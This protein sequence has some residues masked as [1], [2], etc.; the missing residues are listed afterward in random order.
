[1][2]RLRGTGGRFLNTKKPDGKENSDSGEQSKS[3]ET[4]S[5]HLSINSN[6]VSDQR[7]NGASHGFSNPYY[8]RGE[9]GT[10]HFSENNWNSLVNQGPSSSK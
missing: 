9:L 1:M 3:G 10:G 7:S 6:G 2:R 8:A 4:T 5:A